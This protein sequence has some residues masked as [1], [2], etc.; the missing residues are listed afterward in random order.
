MPV[1]LAYVNFSGKKPENVCGR[2]MLMNIRA[3]DPNG[4]I[5]AAAELEMP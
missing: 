2:F 1:I 3:G 5:N 4:I